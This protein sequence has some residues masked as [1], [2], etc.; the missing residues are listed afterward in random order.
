MCYITH[1]DD[2]FKVKWKL[3]VIRLMNTIIFLTITRHLVNIKILKLRKW[4]DTQQG[5]SARFF[6]M[7]S[8]LFLLIRRSIN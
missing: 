6:Q 7:I 1:C 4:N 2:V 3:E 8:R 5:M